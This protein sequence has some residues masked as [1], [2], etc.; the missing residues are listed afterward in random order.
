MVTFCYHI[1]EFG[2]AEIND[3][4]NLFETIKEIP[5]ANNENIRMLGWSRGGMM[6]YLALAKSDKIKTAV[7]GNE[8]SDLFNTLEF[9]PKMESKVFA[10]CIPNYWENKEDELKKRSAIYGLNDLNKNTS[11]LIL[12]GTKDQRV[13]P[14]QASEMF[15]KLVKIDYDVT[16]KSYETNHFFSDKK[17]ELNKELIG[18]FNAKLK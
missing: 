5:K 10:Q 8:A 6:T 16:I 2:G 18:W 1:N 15:K 4:L 9:R 13:N 12:G 14:A 11:L 3:V 7:V 17:E